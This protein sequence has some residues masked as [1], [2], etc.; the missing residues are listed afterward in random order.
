VSDFPDGITAALHRIIMQQSDASANEV[1]VALGEDG[2]VHCFIT[3]VAKGVLKT[4]T[5][6]VQFDAGS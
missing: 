3:K 4:V 5:V 2:V 1:E 6:K